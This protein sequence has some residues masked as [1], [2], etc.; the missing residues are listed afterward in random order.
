MS[1]PGKIQRERQGKKSKELHM[2]H[3]AGAALRDNDLD[4]T[5]AI[6]THYLDFAL[7]SSQPDGQVGQVG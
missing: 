2:S 3:K 5:L 6:Y 7:V 1:A 4:S